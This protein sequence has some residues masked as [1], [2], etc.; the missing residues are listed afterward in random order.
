MGKN[1]QV[2]IMYKFRTMVSDTPQI[3]SNDLKDASRYITNIGKIIRKYSMD[4]I[5]QI[6]NVL[7]GEMTFVGPRPALENQIDLISMRHENDLTSL[8]PG[9]TGLAQI[10]G[11]DNLDLQKKIEFEKI[12][13]KNKSLLYDLKIIA[14]TFKVVVKSKDIIH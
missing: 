4:E 8:T 1:N 3:N 6:F 5:P 2:F 7:K 9:I 11:R 12:Y 10:N 13:K 14:K